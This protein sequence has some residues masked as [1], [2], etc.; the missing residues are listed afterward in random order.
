MS[1][2]LIALICLLAA[3]MQGATVPL[4]K[5]PTMKAA[6]RIAAVGFFLGA[7]KYTYAAVVG[8][9]LAATAITA[10]PLVLLSI[11]SIMNGWA[12]LFENGRWDG[13]DRRAK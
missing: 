9:N 12:Q 3:L 1:D 5:L 7:L 4:V 10:I 6:K 2:I 13:S 8:I 11:A